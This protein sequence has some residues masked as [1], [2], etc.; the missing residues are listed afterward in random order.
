MCGIAAILAFEE[1]SLL[2][3]C[4]L[5]NMTKEINHRG[6]DDEGFYLNDWVGFGFKRLSILD[7]SYDGH[8]PMF[9][10]TKNY[11]IV[12]NGEIYNYKTLREEL[13][14][15]NYKF[16]SNTD[17]E[18]LL[19]SY[20]EWGS[21]CLPKLEGMFAFIIYDKIKEE[22]MVARDHLGI[23]PLYYF[24]KNDYYFFGSE[25]KSFRNLI[26]FE[27]N[28]KQ[29]YEQFLYAYVS[30]QNT[31][32][33]N[34]FRVKP[35]SFLKL[36][37]KGFVSENH[38][39]NVCDTLM[40]ESS[41][42]L[43]LEEIKNDINGSILKHT[44][45]DVGYNVQLSGG[46]DS[47]Y[48]TAVLSK[49]YKQTLNTYS[50]K[51]ENFRGDESKYQKIVSE[52]YNTVHHSY[53]F[54]SKDL[55]DSHEKATWH[56]DIPMVHLGSVL[57]MLLCEHSKNN[58]KVILTGEGSDELFGGYGSFKA[59]KLYKYR[60]PY[61]LQ[62]HH[63]LINLIP[64]ISVLKNIKNSLK[65]FSVG[66]DQSSYFPYEKFKFLFNGLNKNIEYRESV[67]RNLDQL[68]NKVFASFQ[69]SYL[70][71]LFERQDKMSM[72]MSVEARVPFSNHLL[73]DKINKL[74]FKK[75]IRPV[76]KAIL[77]KLAEQYFDK[78]FIYRRKNGFDL[79]LGDWLR[80]GKGLKPWFDLLT[81]KTFHE[82]G[83][84]NHK[85]INSLI[86]KHLNRDEDNSE[87]LINIINFEI[88]HRIFIDQPIP[89]SDI[90]FSNL[91]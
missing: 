81:D 46:V 70:N 88:W 49:E 75:K 15:K 79:P 48:I 41:S 45:S 12:F 91:T 54:G 27:L 71:F 59:F 53:S 29:L 35:G 63:N 83:F 26:K 19:N 17:T 68:V 3:K 47:S 7:I 33:K 57:L 36:N 66:I 58:S 30:G 77:K 1:K 82:R 76:P 55:R 18:V 28:D 72:A 20:I 6:P 21:S 14:K 67:V 60:I 13:T 25:I 50:V 22:V 38:Y 85:N 78:S 90:N 23:K 64:D 42:S 62:H 10:V 39:Y 43:N 5:E 89:K 51:I 37:K 32:F 31:I 56:Y 16:K 61:L 8:Q 86:D 44:M 4:T 74:H 69:T 24:R 52:K 9:D 84:Y 40:N 11:V 80:D 2:N 73:F 65:Y 34:I 87:Y